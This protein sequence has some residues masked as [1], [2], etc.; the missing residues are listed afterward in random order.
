MRLLLYI[1]AGLGIAKITQP[2]S[3]S[4]ATKKSTDVLIDTEAAIKQK[5]QL[6]SQLAGKG[7]RRIEVQRPVIEGN[8][9]A[10]KYK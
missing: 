10:K 1:F 7:T 3:I 8:I 2:S 4:N 6:V 5:P 9:P